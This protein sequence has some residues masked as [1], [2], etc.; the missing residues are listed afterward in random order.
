MK[1]WSILIYKYNYGELGLDLEGEFFLSFMRTFKLPTDKKPLIKHYISNCIYSGPQFRKMMNKYKEFI[2]WKEKD[3]SY[4]FNEDMGQNWL[5]LAKLHESPQYL[6]IPLWL[7]D[8]VKEFKLK[9]TDMIILADIY[10]FQNQG[11]QYK[12]CRE[13][14]S[15]FLDLHVDQ[16]SKKLSKLKDLGLI[17]IVRTKTINIISLTDKFLNYDSRR[18]IKITGKIEQKA[19]SI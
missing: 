18:K 12:K 7:I 13:T 17:E 4:S 9:F 16:I 3:H 2:Y 8:L 6:E 1:D 5:R 15:N 19:S 11:R 10:S 14:I